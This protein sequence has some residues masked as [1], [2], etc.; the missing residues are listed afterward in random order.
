MSRA[1]KLGEKGG[2]G[3]EGIYAR[4]VFFLPYKIFPR[5]REYIETINDAAV[6]LINMQSRL[7]VLW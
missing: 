4:R 6:K 3:G 5:L 2:E 1:L 7:Y